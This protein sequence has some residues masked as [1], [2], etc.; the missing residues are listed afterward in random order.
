MVTGFVIG[1]FYPFHLG[2]MYLLD[3][4]R[5]RCDRLI[6]WV[7]DKA[8]QAIPGDLRAAW[9]RELYPDASVR[10]V[11]DTLPDDDSAAWAA[12]TVRILGRAPDVVFSSEDYGPE[13]ARLMGSQHVMVDR[14]RTHAPVSGTVVRADPLGNW[15]YLAPPV[16]A[17]Y[18]RRIVLVG[19]ESTGK[20]TLAR[21]L[22][23]RYGTAWVPEYGRE[24][25]E[26][27]LLRGDVGWATEEFVHIAAEQNRREDEAAR[28]AERVLICDTDAF[29]TGIWHERYIGTRSDA[30]ARLARPHAAD[31]YLLTGD[32]IPF[33]Q[34]GTR[35][36]ERIRHWMHGRFL[37][38][39]Q[40]RRLPFALLA[41]P[42]DVRM[43]RAAA[44]IDGFLARTDLPAA[45]GSCTLRCA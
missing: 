15:Q 17:H 24:Y 13:Y 16:R 19:A 4:A 40:G 29:A 39:L 2:H 7:C 26:R 20:T 45:A 9:I 22:A 42:H 10:V 41:G 34:D 37:E 21:A 5:S 31:L 11:P 38:E 30:V 36:G 14:V 43:A 32:E 8:Q 25:T 12:Y 23:T 18:V 27:K 33:T 1:K 44:L 35:D 6:V 28:H 3:I